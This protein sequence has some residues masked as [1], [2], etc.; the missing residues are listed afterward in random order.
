M[1]RS[2]SGATRRRRET[3]LLSGTPRTTSG[4]ATTST[5]ARPTSS[6]IGSRQFPAPSA[7]PSGEPTAVARV[8]PAPTM[9]SARPRF[10]GRARAAAAAVAV[11][12]RAADPRPDKVRPARKRVSVSPAVAIAVPSAKTARPAVISNDRGTRPSVIDTSGAVTA[13]TSE[14][15]VIE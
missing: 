2:P 4:S 11:G 3:G 7:V 14:Y 5:A 13:T 6:H 12:T 9:A 1:R 10:S 15:D 8:K